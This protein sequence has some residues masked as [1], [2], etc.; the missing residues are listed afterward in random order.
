MSI[1]GDSASSITVTN[2]FQRSKHGAAMIK[3]T[4]RQHNGLDGTEVDTEARHVLFE[5][6]VFRPGVE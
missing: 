6:G 4:M 2:E 3:M 1:V 5:Y